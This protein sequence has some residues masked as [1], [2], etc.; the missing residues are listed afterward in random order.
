MDYPRGLAGHS[1]GDVIAQRSSTQSSARRTS[2]T[3]GRSSRRATSSTAARRRST[4]SRRPTAS[5]REAGWELVNADCV[6][7]GEE[8]RIGDVRDEMS[9]RLAGALG[10]E[11]ARDRG[12]CDDDG[13][14]RVHVAEAKGL[15]AQAV[16]RCGDERSSATRIVPICSTS[17]STRSLRRRSPSTRTTTSRDA[18][19]AGSTLDFPDFQVGLLDGEELVAEAHAIPVPG[20]RPS[21]ERSR[22]AGTRDSMPAW[23]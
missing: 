18:T 20:T 2:E 16:A 1:D 23:R 6:L 17:G 19:G 21:T 5:V 7:I 3:S 12:A 15:A 9:E 4:C 10:V 8:P 13:P 14:P 22:P 11:S